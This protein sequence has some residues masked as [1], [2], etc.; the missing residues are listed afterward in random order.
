LIITSDGLEYRYLYH[1]LDNWIKT[2]NSKDK[3]GNLDIKGPPLQILECDIGNGSLGYN[4]KCAYRDYNFQLDGFSTSA[5][6]INHIK[7][8]GT[9]YDNSGYYNLRAKEG[10]LPYDDGSV[11][12]L[13][14]IDTLDA[15]PKDIGKIFLSEVKRVSHNAIILVANHIWKFKDFKEDKDWK[16]HGF[17]LNIPKNRNPTTLDSII[18]PWTFGYSKYGFYFWSRTLFAVYQGQQYQTVESKLQ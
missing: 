11:D 2:K 4:L 13:I 9:A 8:L 16:V 12:V 10:I 7:N 18:S 14:A 15:L 3:Y 6:S 1:H 17:G 5:D